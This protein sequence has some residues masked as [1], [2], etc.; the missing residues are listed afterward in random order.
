MGV[1]V[2]FAEQEHMSM[3]A[4]VLQTWTCLNKRRAYSPVAE[5]ADKARDLYTSDRVPKMNVATPPN[6]LHSPPFTY[7]ARLSQCPIPA[8]HHQLAFLT[9]GM[10]PSSAFIR[11]GYCIRQPMTHKR[12]AATLGRACPSHAKVAEHATTF[13]S[14]YTPVPYLRWSS[15]AVHL[16]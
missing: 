13:P 9:P 14:F 3:L 8:S 15:V 12:N 10:F 7:R 2:K 4:A 11:K 16:R 1:E 6:A 5:G